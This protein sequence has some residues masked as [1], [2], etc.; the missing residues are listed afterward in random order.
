MRKRGKLLAGKSGILMGDWFIMT[1]HSKQKERN[2][3]WWVALCGCE[4][5]LQ[6]IKTKMIF[7][8]GLVRDRTRVGHDYLVYLVLFSER[9]KS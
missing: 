7:F 2:V 8:R 5:K 6:P 3:V 4:K 9:K 1:A